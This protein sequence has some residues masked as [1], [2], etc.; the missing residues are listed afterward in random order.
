MKQA[1]ND[2]AAE[3]DE[4]LKRANADL[5]SA[6]AKIAALEKE[7]NLVHTESKGLHQEVADL[8]K[9]LEKMHAELERTK[10]AEH[11]AKDENA[12]TTKLLDKALTKQK[13]S[14]AETEAVKKG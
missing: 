8:R 5:K 1:N 7:L 3:L 2:H 12:N 13:E 14:Q 9:E 10:K 6:A 11:A 4:E